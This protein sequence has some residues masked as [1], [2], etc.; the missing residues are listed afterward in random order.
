MA[1]RTLTK[2]SY[3]KY[4]LGLI[5][6][7]LLSSIFL[8]KSAN[9]QVGTY[10][11][12]S[13]TYSIYTYSCQL[14]NTGKWGCVR[15]PASIPYT[16]SYFVNDVIP[17]SNECTAGAQGVCGY[18]QNA[19]QTCQT[20]GDGSYKSD[21]SVTIPPLSLTTTGCSC[22]AP[23]YGDGSC[24]TTRYSCTQG[25]DVNNNGN[26]WQCQ[27]YGGGKTVSCSVGCTIN[28]SKVYWCDGSCNEWAAVRDCA[29]GAKFNTCQ[30]GT[31]ELAANTAACNGAGGMT[32]PVCPTPAT[33]TF[34]A[35]ANLCGG[36]NGI[37]ANKTVTWTSVSGASQYVLRIDDTS[38]AP[39]APN[40]TYVSGCQGVTQYYGDWCGNVTGTSFAYNFIAGDTYRINVTATNTCGKTGTSSPVSTFTI[41][42]TTC[43]APTCNVMTVNPTQLYVGGNPPPATSALNIASCVAG[44]STSGPVT[45]AWTALVAGTINPTNAATATYTP[46]ATGTTYTQVNINPT[47]NV[48]NPGGACMV[49]TGGL[50]LIPTFKVTGEVY[51]DVDKSGTLDS[52][53]D[54]PYTTVSTIN[55][56]QI[57]GN[58]CN[59]YETLYSNPSDGTFSTQN[60]KP[61]IPGQYKATLTVISPYKPT[62]PATVIFTVGNASTGAACQVPSPADC[63]PDNSGNIENLNFGL[64][65]SFSWMQAIGGD[66]TGNAVSDSNGGGFT[67]PIPD[68]AGIVTP[69]GAYTMINGT[70]SSTHGLIV[71]GSKDVNFGQGQEAVANEWLV[72]GFGANSYPYV[73]NLP[74]SNQAKTAYA[75]LSYL[76][77]QSNIPTV[78]LDTIPDCGTPN[79]NCL[80][81]SDS[82]LF[83]SG[84]YTVDGDLD[85]RSASGTYTF[86]NGKYT[87]LVNGNLNI[88]T[89]VIVPQGSFVLFSVAKNINV[90]KTVGEAIPTTCSLATGAGCDLEGYYSTDQSFNVLSKD[91]AGKGANCADPSDP[92]LQLNV[93]GAIV[94]NASTTNGGSFNYNSRDM[95]AYDTQWPVFTI[96]ERPDFVLNFP[97]FLM[98]PRRTW[99]EVAP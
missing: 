66:I 16:C 3:L 89:K 85:L 57:V 60:V 46:P 36:A 18:Y 7:F 61:L 32:C 6:F 68:P 73:Y 25:T 35:P 86:P 63:T 98:F 79:N 27:G 1:I 5:L 30:E 50:N 96:T 10:C 24:G 42:N 28:C 20:I 69:N 95:C 37:I 74:L 23:A 47:V 93:A 17:A 94:V 4:V 56:C 64:T 48:C 81:T 92:D 75:N 76:V 41:S 55:I 11:T 88:N 97:T 29:A 12:G 58:N 40:K 14:L 54:H 65:N 26:T 15:A 9:A 13:G 70:D 39:R 43:P 78:N 99:Q 19:N 53:I 2:S 84:V 21:C 34:S 67:N 83:G 31:T 82:N 22:I 38:Q 72:G 33:P 51:V 49:Y 45:Y 80:L 52:N 71:T 77:K 87:I 44:G 62:N 59:T 90:A 91:I 8:V